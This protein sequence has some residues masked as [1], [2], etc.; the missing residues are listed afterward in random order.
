MF[1][2]RCSHLPRNSVCH[3]LKRI[4]LWVQINVALA[5]SVPLLTTYLSQKWQDLHPW[6][7]ISIGHGGAR[8]LW[9]ASPPTPAAGECAPS[10]QVH[11]P[12]PTAKLRSHIRHKTATSVRQWPPRG[13]KG[14]IILQLFADTPGKGHSHTFPPHSSTERH[15]SEL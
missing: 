10:C 13:N 11:N 4:H 6:A 12:R 8:S 14:I 9:S 1:T 15:L 2:P 3:V 5:I 7:S